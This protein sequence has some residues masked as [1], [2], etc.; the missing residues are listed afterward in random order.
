MKRLFLLAIFALSCVLGVVTVNA[1]PQPDETVYTV[2]EV[3]PQYPGGNDAMLAFLK[4]NCQFPAECQSLNVASTRVI[5]QVVIK[6][7]GTIGDIKIVR[8]G[9]HEAFGKEL[10]RVIKLMPKWTPGQQGGQA[11]S[12]RK[13]LVHEF[14]KK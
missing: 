5:A 2:V 12:V 4:E 7:D 14:V 13:M 3:Q 6:A 1:A 11:V 8:N 10:T 9:G